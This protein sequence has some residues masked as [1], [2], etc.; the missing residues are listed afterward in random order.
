MKSAAK[1]SLLVSSCLA[2][3]CKQKIAKRSFTYFSIELPLSYL[4]TLALTII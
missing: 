1:F 3:Y 2:K 4:L